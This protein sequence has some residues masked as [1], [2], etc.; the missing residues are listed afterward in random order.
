[1]ERRNGSKVWVTYDC[2]GS[3][4]KNCYY[5]QEISILPLNSNSP[6]QT[7]NLYDQHFSIFK[8]LSWVEQNSKQWKWQKTTKSVPERMLRIGS[9]SFTYVTPGK[10]PRMVHSSRHTSCRSFWL[11][12]KHMSVFSF[13]FSFNLSVAKCTFLL[14][15]IYD[16]IISIYWH[17]FINP[18]VLYLVSYVLHLNKYPKACNTI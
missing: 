12:L 16:N 7:P 2:C 14:P 13:S 11:L 15:K 10:L 8:M 18:Y 9:S 5:I 4:S 3:T 1:M 17:L 6:T